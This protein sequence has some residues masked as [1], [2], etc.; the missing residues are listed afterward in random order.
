MARA[1]HFGVG[2]DALR[3]G[4]TFIGKL[5]EIV[6]AWV[7]DRVNAS[8]RTWQGPEPAGTLDHSRMWRSGAAASPWSPHSLVIAGGEHPVPGIHEIWVRC[9]VTSL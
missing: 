9:M 6:E 8:K 7:D 2:V 4:V 5:I 1:G 3:D